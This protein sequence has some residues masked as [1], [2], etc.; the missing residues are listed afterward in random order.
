ML[1]EIYARQTLSGD[2]GLGP[3]IDFSTLLK[4]GMTWLVNEH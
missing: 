4:R 3:S 2:R 1:L